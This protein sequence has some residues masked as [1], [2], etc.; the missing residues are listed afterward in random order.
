MAALLKHDPLSAI[1]E[2]EATGETAKV[3]ADIRATMKL[4]MITSIWRTLA[5]VPGGLQAT[6]KAIKPLFES[7]Y[8]DILLDQL[9][10]PEFLPIPPLDA[11]KQLGALGLSEETW[12]GVGNIIDAYTRSNSLNLLALSALHVEPAGELPQ[13]ISA[14]NAE[15]I[16]QLPTLLEY[17]EIAPKIWQLLLKINQFGASPDEPGLATLWR[18]LA[19]WPSFL[20]VIN[21]VLVPLQEEGAIASS[22]SNVLDVAGI[23]GRRLALLL[24]DNAEIPEPARLMI[25]KYVTHPG[26]VSRMV[27][28]G[29]GLSL[30]LQSDSDIVYG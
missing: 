16:P 30:W 4:P 1:S 19:H 7:G 20:S 12:A 2:A 9:L 18:H 5:G 24:S 6:W 17:D 22:I 3:F 14:M 27:A 29:N 28:I 15:P 26:L 8:P 11:K 25:E 13:G 23:E 10:K 21:D